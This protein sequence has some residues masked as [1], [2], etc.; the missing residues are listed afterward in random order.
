MVRPVEVESALSSHPSVL[1]AAV[2]G[3]EDQ[4]KLIKPQAYVVLKSGNQPSDALAE[5]LKQHVRATLVPVKYPR[6]IVFVDE[7]PK[8]AT[9]KMQRYL[10]RQRAAEESQEASA[11]DEST[12]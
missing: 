5:E 1:E 6:W 11:L 4:D 3:R 2:V 9:G 8:T 12:L 10:L 7:L